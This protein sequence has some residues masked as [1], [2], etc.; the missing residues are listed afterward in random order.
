MCVDEWQSADS[1]RREVGKD[2]PSLVISQCTNEVES[3]TS[4]Q[5]VQ[6]GTGDSAAEDIPP[7]GYSSLY[8]ARCC[9]ASLQR[10][11]GKD[12]DDVDDGVRGRSI[13]P[14]ALPLPRLHVLVN[15]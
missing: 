6:R 15:R 8:L 4:V 14:L 1:E 11:S 12:D 7:I 9:D 2:C 3:S 10:P 13:T 5:R